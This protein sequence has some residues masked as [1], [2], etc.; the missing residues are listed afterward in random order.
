[1]SGLMALVAVFLVFLGFNNLKIGLNSKPNQA[2]IN[3]SIETDNDWDDDG[4]NNREESYWN[5]DPNNSDTDSDGYLDGEEVASEHDPLI[6]GSDDFLP[7]N[8]NLTKK[9]ALLMVSGLVEGS[10]KPEN[11]NYGQSL[12][13]LAL[14]IEEDAKNSFK[15]DLTKVKL[16]T[17]NSDRSSQQSYIE[18]FSTV[19]E[20]LLAIFVGQMDDLEGNL[21]DIGLRG[22][23]D[24]KVISSFE[25]ASA[26]YQRVFE[27]FAKIS[28]PKEWQPNHLG[29]IKLAGE[30]SQASQSVVNG[31]DDPIKSTVGLNKIVG[32]WEILPQITEAYS[33]KL[34]NYKLNPEKTIFK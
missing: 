11:S 13:A 20:K 30:L 5:T 9:T 4:L 6:A 34:Q 26:D 28:V 33:Q 7:T 14:T 25:K 17:A 21:I 10:L 23:S 2:N 8:D 15:V 19:F 3:S 31:K 22:F 27:E 18:E 24:Q 29:M 16:Q 32:L 12:D 1:M